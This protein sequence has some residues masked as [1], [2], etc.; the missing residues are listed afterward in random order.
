MNTPTLSMLKRLQAAEIKVAESRQAKEVAEHEVERCESRLAESD[1]QIE[2]KQQA[3]AVKQDAL[4]AHSR[5]ITA[6]EKSL[7]ELL[8]ASE[9]EETEPERETLVRAVNRERAELNR[10]EQNRARL[11][12]ETKTLQEQRA[13][14]ERQRRDIAEKLIRAE[15][16]LSRSSRA[17]RRALQHEE[18]VQKTCAPQI[19]AG[20]LDV[21]LA[22]ARL[23]DGEGLAKLTKTHPKRG[24][25]S[26]SGCHMCVS[27]DTIDSMK[28]SAA[29]S[30]CNIC[31]RI[32][33]LNGRDGK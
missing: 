33:Y 27:L 8:D 26:C 15:R 32:L 29:V 24:E 4:D 3:R 18:E 14:T 16:N 6:R 30:M 22:A 31:G 2:K 23:H 19:E 11:E 28:R 10:L 17:D 5:E 13:E 7:S 9:A 21:F 20:V 25:Y 12:Q 1:A